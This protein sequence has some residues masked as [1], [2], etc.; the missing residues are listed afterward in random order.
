MSKLE[1][2]PKGI[3]EISKHATKPTIFIVRKK[4]EDRILGKFGNKR[5]AELFANELIK[6]TNRFHIVE[7]EK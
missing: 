2:L 6:N 7:E 5:R 4:D 3:F 1:N